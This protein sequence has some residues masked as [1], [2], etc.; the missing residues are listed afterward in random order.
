MQARV[1]L[2][3]IFHRVLAQSPHVFAS[4]GAIARERT[5]PTV[6][7]EAFGSEEVGCRYL[8]PRIWKLGA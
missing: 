5:L 3:I 1:T 7:L 2:G 6:E 8:L 4:T